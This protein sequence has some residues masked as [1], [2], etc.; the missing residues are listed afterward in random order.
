MIR[1]LGYREH[2]LQITTTCNKPSKISS[3][4]CYGVFNYQ[5]TWHAFNKNVPKYS[6]YLLV[7]VTK[8]RQVY[9]C[10][11]RVEY[12]CFKLGV[13]RWRFLHSCIAEELAILRVNYWY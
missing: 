10:V 8:E 13:I 6:I 12:S 11:S 3:S 9:M 1:S 2:I 7:Y 5:V 4:S